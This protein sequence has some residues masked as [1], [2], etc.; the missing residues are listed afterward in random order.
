MI[1]PILTVTLRQV[2]LRPRLA[3]NIRKRTYAEGC[4]VADAFAGVNLTV[5]S[6]RQRH[7]IFARAYRALAFVSSPAAILT[8]VSSVTLNFPRSIAPK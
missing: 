6:V 3:G 2:S 1:L 5:M 8:S 7:H 4:Q